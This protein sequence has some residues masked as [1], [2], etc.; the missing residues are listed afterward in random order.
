MCLAAIVVDISEVTT[1]GAAA[2]KDVC[3]GVI[4]LLSWLGISAEGKL[5]VQLAQF[6]KHFF[7]LVRLRTHTQYILF[8]LIHY[9][10]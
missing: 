3:F 4:L 2:A 8:K 7:L 6:H 9:S 1:L 5:H 10:L